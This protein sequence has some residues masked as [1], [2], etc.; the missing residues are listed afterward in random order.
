MLASSISHDMNP[1][2]EFS[3]HFYLIRS[4]PE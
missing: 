2:G 1:N 4:P 3:V